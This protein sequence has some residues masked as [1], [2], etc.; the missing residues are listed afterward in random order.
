MGQSLCASTSPPASHENRVLPPKPGLGSSKYGPY[1][2][3]TTTN[4]WT[5]HTTSEDATL[6]T[7]FATEKELKAW[8]IQHVTITQQISQSIVR[9][10]GS[11]A[12]AQF[13]IA[14]CED[15]DIY[16]MDHSSTVS[17][18]RCKNCRIYIGPCDSSVFLREC[19]GCTFVI[20][21]RQLRTRDCKDNDVL[22]FCG[23][24]PVIEKTKK[25]RLGCYHG[26]YFDLQKHLDTCA[27]SK[28][29]NRWHAVHDFTPGSGTGQNWSVLQEGT[30]GKDLGMKDI[31]GLTLHG[32]P[33]VAAVVPLTVPTKQKVSDRLVFFAPTVEGMK[34]GDE[35][36]LGVGSRLVDCKHQAML[37]DAWP[38]SQASTIKKK[39]REACV[40]RPGANGASKD[41]SLQP[42]TLV[43]RVAVGGE[44]GAVPETNTEHWG[45]LDQGKLMPWFDQWGLA[46]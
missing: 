9:Q 32:S 11:V 23:T 16:L 29:H 36:V 18:D 4:T 27:L 38:L 12:G 14:D 17:V 42:K 7:S 30:T 20:A 45:V 1:R 21:T 19:N 22:L 25:L 2:K 46:V 44:D 24:E 37:P 33:A 13:I 28:Y 10:P 3:N 41:V 5:L 8:L 34:K 43:V 39:M 26:T 6:P 15:C 31:P 40:V 35:C